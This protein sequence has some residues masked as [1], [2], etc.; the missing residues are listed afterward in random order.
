M[1]FDATSASVVA[2]LLSSSKSHPPVTMD[3]GTLGCGC[4]LITDKSSNIE[5]KTRVG[6][7]LCTKRRGKK[8]SD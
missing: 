2:F 3:E 4:L 8:E 7:A 5:D 6:P 1:G